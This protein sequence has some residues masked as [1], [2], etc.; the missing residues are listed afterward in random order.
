VAARRLLI[1]MIVLLVLSS[2]AAVLI[3]VKPAPEPKVHPTTTTEPA[4]PPPPEGDLVKRVIDA[5][6]K[7]PPT[8]RLAPGDQLDLDVRS[9][10][11]DQVEIPGFGELQ[12]TD[13][14]FAAHF[15]LLAFDPG[16]YPVRLVGAN[17]VIGRIVVSMP[18]R[19]A[20]KDGRRSGATR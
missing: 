17:R 5:A 19:P 18:R 8:I 9:P 6:A 16:T 14:D 4:I 12:D 2:L 7:R 3:P 10:R 1:I 15:N 13:P 20:A 11:P